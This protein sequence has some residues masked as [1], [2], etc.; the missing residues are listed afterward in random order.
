MSSKI[1]YSGTIR[2]GLTLVMAVLMVT[3][4]VA[5]GVGTVAAEEEENDGETHTVDS[6]HIVSE[7]HEDTDTFESEVE[8]DGE[9]LDRIEFTLETTDSGNEVYVEDEGGETLDSHTQTTVSG[10]DDYYTLDDFDGVSDM[11]ITVGGTLETA[12]D[13]TVHVYAETDADHDTIGAALDVAESGD[14]IDIQSDLH[15]D[16]SARIDDDMDL[17]IAGADPGEDRHVLTVDESETNVFDI[18]GAGTIEM[19]GLHLQHD[20]TWS[21]QNDTD[22]VIAYHNTF[23]ST[24]G[25]YTVSVELYG[26]EDNELVV[27]MAKNLWI[28]ADGDVVEPSEDEG[29]YETGTYDAD[30]YVDVTATPYVVDEEFSELSN[31]E[32]VFETD[33]DGD[34]ESDEV[35][36]KVTD[37]DSEPVEGATVTV[38]EETAE[39]DEDGI[40]TF[41]ADAV[42]EDADVSVEHADYEGGELTVEQVESDDES[43]FGVG[44]DGDGI[45]TEQIM[46][47]AALITILGALVGVV[48]LVVRD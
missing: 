4:M 13:V 40:A 47:V 8:L 18:N 43:W 15:L 39:T 35:E 1:Q 24:D 12:Q 11:T 16:E 2:T 33:S 17:T 14:I 42:D 19:Y 48:A 31:G 26:E 10:S 6:G 25:E 34:E 44:A 27:D 41:D 32:P 38:G 36:Y 3:S 7:E 5:M 28:D 21:A 30:E 20:Y 46:L 9:T 22:E 37:E 45:S 23:E 29:D